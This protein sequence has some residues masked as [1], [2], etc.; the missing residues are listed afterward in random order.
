MT[1]N[2]RPETYGGP[3]STNDELVHAFPSSDEGDNQFEYKLA[4]D[5][6]KSIPPLQDLTAGKGSKTIENSEELQNEKD[7]L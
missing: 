2:V 7:E 6:T 4:K 1:K 3:C 5:K